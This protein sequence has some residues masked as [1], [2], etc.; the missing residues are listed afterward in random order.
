MFNFWR[1]TTGVVVFQYAVVL[2]IFLLVTMGT[3]DIAYMLFEWDLAN[4]ATY[5]GARTAAVSNP[6]AQHI[7][8]NTSLNYTQVQ[9]DHINQACFNFSTGAPTDWGCPSTGLVTCTSSACT[10]NTYGFDS[11]AFTNVNGTGIFDRM[12]AVFPRLQVENVTVT[13]QTNGS[14]F[15]G[16]PG[17]LP[18]NITVSITGMTHEFFFVPSLVGVFGGAFSRTKQIPPFSTTMQSEDM[19]TN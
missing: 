19:V 14:G 9:I 17:G 12:K 6:V 8:D 10:P 1:D 2:P 13:Y 4:K 7:T 3:V 15:V 5:V 16:R 18:M 11:S